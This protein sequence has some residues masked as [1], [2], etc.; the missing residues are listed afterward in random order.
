M[1][2]VNQKGKLFPAAAFF[3][4]R[5]IARGEEITFN[6]DTKNDGGKKKVRG[7]GV[8]V[9]ETLGKDDRSTHRGGRVHVLFFAHATL[10]NS[11]T[12]PQGRD[13]SSTGGVQCYCGAKKCRGNL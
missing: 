1:R 11:T 3:A 5:D 13:G 4:S 12:R 8:D 10:P 7:L 2:K 6:Y 9:D